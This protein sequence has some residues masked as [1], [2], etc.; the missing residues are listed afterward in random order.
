MEEINIRQKND[1]RL[2]D[3]INSIQNENHQVKILID[4]NESTHSKSRRITTLL[5]NTKMIDFITNMHGAID[6]PNIYKRG[7]TIIYFIFCTRG[8]VCFIV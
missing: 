2:I 7:P 6:E 8:I 3:F 1:K 5:D 4:K